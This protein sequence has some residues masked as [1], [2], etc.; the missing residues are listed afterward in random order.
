LT[1][2]GTTTMTGWLLQ[3]LFQCTSQLAMFPSTM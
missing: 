1:V 3:N 2:V